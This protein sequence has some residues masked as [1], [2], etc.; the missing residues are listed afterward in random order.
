M[1]RIVIACAACLVAVAA[2]FALVSATKAA[3][4]SITVTAQFDEASGLYAGNA[5]EVLGMQVGSVVDVTPRDSH[6]DV[7]LEIDEEVKV[8]ADVMAV[9]ISTSVLTDRRVELSPPYTTGPVLRDHDLIT[10]DRTR[11]PVGFDRVLQ[12]IDDLAGDLRGDGAGGGPLADLVSAGASVASD[13]GSNV[14]TA[15][16]EL[17]EALRMTSDGVHTRDQITRIVSDLSSLTEAM[18][19]NDETVRQFGSF[20]RSTS[21][22]LAAEQ[23]GTG[24]TGRKA[25]EVLTQAGE[26]L[27]THEETIRAAVQNSNSILSAVDDN[28]RQLAE[29]FD[30]LPLMLD[31]VYN[32][33]D[34]VNG[35]LRVHALVDKILF[36]SQLTKEV[37]NLMGL[38]QLGCS[39]GTLQDY[40]PDFG[41][42]H[43]LD[44]MVRMGQG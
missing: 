22:I 20:V 12:M 19:A 14:K 16:D 41:L 33:I 34:P 9:T 31:N 30:V 5:V 36:D 28:Q 2:A 27:E 39:T 40:G 42:T 44:S 15:L 23:F 17:S 7:T 29:A 43:M 6:V 35:S 4:G 21:E 26:L 38:R 8:P 13:N 3:G 24:E 32:T 18:S 11:T 37:C 1:R 25:N 10:L